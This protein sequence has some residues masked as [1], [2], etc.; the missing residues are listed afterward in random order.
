MRPPLALLRRANQ[1]C[2]GVLK[3]AAS[4]DSELGGPQKSCRVLGYRH[5]VLAA[6]QGRLSIDPA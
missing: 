4:P 6:K 3:P 1:H 5:A 2:S